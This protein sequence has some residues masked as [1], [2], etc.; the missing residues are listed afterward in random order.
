MDNYGL[1]IVDLSKVGYKDDPWVLGN[2]VAQVFYAQPG[3][4]CPPARLPC[5]VNLAITVDDVD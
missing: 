3:T 5:G 1:R 2:R 4:R